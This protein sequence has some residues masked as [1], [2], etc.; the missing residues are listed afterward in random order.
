[1]KRSNGFNARH[2]RNRGNCRWC[3]RLAMAISAVLACLGILLSMAGTS[4]L[5]GHPA[6]LELPG[7][8]LSQLGAGV[9]LLWLGIFAWR[10]CR[11]KQRR[12]SQLSLAPHLMK[13]S[14]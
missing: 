4:N 2:L 6:A 3:W 13:K 7:N 5:L 12:H 8:A 10:V 9:L 1:M 11:A 14:H